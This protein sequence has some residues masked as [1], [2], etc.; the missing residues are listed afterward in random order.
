[1]TGIAVVIA[2]PEG[3][4]ERGLS[5][6][7]TLREGST[8]LDA[9]A[10]DVVVGILEESPLHLAGSEFSAPAD[11]ARWQLIL[12]M[13]LILAGFLCHLLYVL[14]HER[15]PEKEG[16]PFVASV[17]VWFTKRLDRSW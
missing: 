3:V 2:A 11:A 12:G 5:L 9:A 13:L 4:M 10:E 8:V 6:A 7:A 1:M 16:G 14:R 17:R 15:L